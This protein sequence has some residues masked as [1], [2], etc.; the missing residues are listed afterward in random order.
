MILRPYQ[1]TG[2]YQI[3]AAF[4]AAKKRI[5]YVAPTGSGKTTLFAFIVHNAAA[6]GNRVLILCHRTELVDQISAAL[7][8]SGTPHGFI[9]AAYPSAAHSYPVVIASVQTLVR[10][11]EQTPEPQLIIVD[12]CHHSRAES[13]EK[14]LTRWP[15]AKVLGVTATPIRQSGEG[16]DT[17]FD[18]MIVGPTMREL[19]E[20]GYLA[21]YRL[22]APET[23]DTSGLHTRAGEF[24]SAESDALVNKAVIT[25]SA[26]AHYKQHAD[27]RPALVFCVSIAHAEAVAAQFRDGGYAAVSLN[28]GIDRE[29]RRGIIRDFRAGCARVITSC[30]ILNEGFDVPGAHCGIFLRPTQSLGLWLQ[31][32]GR[33]MRPCEGKSHAILLDHVGNTSRPGLGLPDS[34]R[35]WSL[36]GEPRSKSDKAA[37]APRVCP[38]CWAASPPRSTVCRECEQAFPV[39]SRQ[40]DEREG[41][42]REVTPTDWNAYEKYEAERRAKGARTWEQARADSL[43]ALEALGRSRG[44]KPGWARRIW[45]TRQAKRA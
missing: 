8:E 29:I 17:L 1:S 45:A 27:N 11:L 4:Q 41:E 31:Q 16:L 30:D 19:I 44:Y 24:V 22:F 40:V 9:A 26:L 37:P 38:R 35:Q 13:Y 5:V 25:G 21:K 28:G 2:V 12:E 6:K 7:T 34:E 3:R 18:H 10:R 20:Q 32:L 43:E 23:V 14:I 15:R 39:E 36:A 42:L 33:I